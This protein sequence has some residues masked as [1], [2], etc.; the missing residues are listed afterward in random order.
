MSVSPRAAKTAVASLLLALMFSGAAATTAFG[1]ASDASIDGFSLLPQSVRDA[2][3]SEAQS[4]D[5]FS[6]IPETSPALESAGEPAKMKTPKLAALVETNAADSA[7]DAEEKCLASAIFFEA[8][9]ESFEGQLAVARVILNRVQSGRFA[10]S[11]CGVVL[12]PSQFS[13]VRGG[14]IPAISTASKDWREALAIARIAQAKLHPSSA[15][16]ALFFHATHVSPKWRLNR[17]A[18]IGNHIFYR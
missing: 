2:A 11:I 6:F 5:N 10:G 18:S 7:V 3:V 14:A 9:S 15:D 13:F 16:N 1:A 4:P 17:V 12:Q 8:R